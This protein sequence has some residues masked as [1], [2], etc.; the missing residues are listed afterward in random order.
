MTRNRKI[1]D[2]EMLVT[3]TPEETKT[4]AERETPVGSAPTPEPAVFVAQLAAT[5]D[6]DQ[7]QALIRTI[8]EQVGNREAERIIRSVKKPEEES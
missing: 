5:T 4:K 2:D 1:E 3:H 8:Q 7:R 6:P